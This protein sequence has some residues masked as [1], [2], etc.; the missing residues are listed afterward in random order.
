MA[1][2][3]IVDDEVALVEALEMLLTDVGHQVQAVNSAKEALEK[4]H[5]AEQNPDLIVADVLM[6]QMNG[7]EL[8]KTVRENPSWAHIPVL[9]ISAST[10]MEMEVQM[11]KLGKASF[12]RKPFE[13]EKLFE[14]IDTMLQD[15]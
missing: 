1:D 10:T 12:L 15:E 6:P 3:L 5:E 8:I 9:F 14:A 2:L 13:V 11:G 7:F 4:L